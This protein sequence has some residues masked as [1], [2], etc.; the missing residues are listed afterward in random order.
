MFFKNLVKSLYARIVQPVAVIARIDPHSPDP[1]PLHRLVNRKCRSGQ[2]GIDP[3]DVKAGRTFERFCQKLLRLHGVVVED[4]VEGRHGACRDP[5]LFPDLLKPL[6]AA[7]IEPAEGPL[8]DKAVA[9]K[10]FAHFPASPSKPKSAAVFF[11]AIFSRSA[12]VRSASTS[13]P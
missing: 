10:P 8:T 3:H 2:G 7:V 5:G 12:G 13:W 4:T 6:H 9:V 1:E 11:H